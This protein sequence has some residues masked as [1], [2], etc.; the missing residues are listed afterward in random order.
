MKKTLKYIYNVFHKYGVMG[1]M[2]NFY[3]KIFYYKSYKYYSSVP[4]EK[5]PDELSKW[6]YYVS[7]K[8]LDLQHPKTFNEKIQWLKIYDNIPLKTKLSDKY[9]VCDWVE[10]KIGEKYL[11]PLLGVWDQY[12]DI[13][14][15]MLPSRF[16][17]KTNHG[18]GGNI[19]VK[20]SARLNHIDT[21]KKFD[22]W[23]SINYA[24]CCGFELQYKDITPKIIAEEYISNK[25]G[26]TLYDYKVHCFHGVPKAIQV[27]GD[28]E[29]TTKEAFFDVHWN[30][31]PCTY[32][33]PPYDRLIPKPKNLEELLE[34]SAI[35]SKDFYYVRVD[36]YI[37][38]DGS[39]KFGE[40]TFT[41][42]SGTSRWK[43]QSYAEKMGDLIHVP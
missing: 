42:T 18:S 17:L 12:D 36:F 7:G 43:P 10:N 32:T 29:R 19:I 39:I 3:R 1:T 23:M 6:F 28:R 26:E 30:L 11:I 37:L 33:N 4:K 38:D 16:V 34:V 25:N 21:K 35:L 15:S 40:M 5:Y 13:D 22:K 9:L 31:L 27:V 14:F 20:D 8:K 24:F 2:F 41:P